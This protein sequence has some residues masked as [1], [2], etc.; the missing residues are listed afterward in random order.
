MACLASSISL[1]GPQG[2]DVPLIEV[3]ESR[4]AGCRCGRGGSDQGSQVG[5][6]VNDPVIGIQGRSK[7]AQNCSPGPCWPVKAVS[8]SLAGN[9]RH[10]QK[11][12]PFP[13]SKSIPDNPFREGLAR[14]EQVWGIS[15]AP[16][17]GTHPLPCPPH[18]A[19][20]PGTQDC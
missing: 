3:L 12:G 15:S 1:Y 7:R 16:D 14:P 2:G 20:L 4:A 10:P 18:P 19:V 5:P 11:R 17:P 9:K 13:T 8:P 6:P